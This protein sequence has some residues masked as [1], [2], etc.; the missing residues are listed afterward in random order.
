MLVIQTNR[1]LFNYLLS[2]SADGYKN[3]YKMVKEQFGEE[4]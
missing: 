2:H 1:N 3:G 4:P